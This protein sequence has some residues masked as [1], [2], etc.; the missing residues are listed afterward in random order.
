MRQTLER[1][2]T[3]D[4][5]LASPNHALWLRAALIG[6]WLAALCAGCTE[7]ARRLSG[8]EARPALDLGGLVMVETVV[9]NPETGLRDRRAT[10]FYDRTTGQRVDGLGLVIESEFSEGL[11][12]ARREG[13][14]RL[15]YVDAA[16]R[17]AIP[18]RYYT[19]EPFH[20]GRAVVSVV[21]GDGEPR[22]AL[23]DRSGNWV[24]APGRH[25]EL[26]AFREG[27]CAFRSGRRWGLLDALGNEVVPPRF[28]EAP[29]F[30]D[31][32]AAIHDE[33][34]RPAFIDRRG[35]VSLRAPE[36]ATEVG[37]FHDGLARF[38]AVD[39]GSG[40]GG[41]GLFSKPRYGYITVAGSVAVAAAYAQ[42]GDFSEGL[43]AV[44]RNAEVPLRGD[45]DPVEHAFDSG[46]KDS[47][48]Y[49]DAAGREAIAP[50]FNR[51][52]RFSCG[53]ARV[54]LNGVWGYIDKAGRLVIPPRYQWA[55]DFRDGLAEVWLSGRIVI[56]DRTGTVV[57][58][59]GLAAAT[60]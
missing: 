49:I 51:A 29:G 47:W 13:Q 3:D 39:A 1:R 34:G 9:A 52:G 50:Q 12:V 57:V 46:E 33:A 26:G 40:E 44:S 16:G 22:Y 30:H 28:P 5:R 42:A 18:F 27:R 60:F 21:G 54:R 59:T 41:S 32:L 55:R 15:G 45:D 48:G 23:I 38:A 35:R 2:S 7:D 10:L 25:E 58:E 8:T 24:V 36:G 19:A 56:V 37:D 53:L 43:A 4:P 6:G 11:A 17:T 20:E 14:E 31:G